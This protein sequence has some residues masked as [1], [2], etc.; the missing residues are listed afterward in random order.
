MQWAQSAASRNICL[1]SILHAKCPVSGGGANKLAFIQR[2]VITLV[3]ESFFTSYIPV[4]FSLAVFDTLCFQYD[5][6]VCISAIACCVVK[7]EA[8]AKFCD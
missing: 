6:S 3:Y 5:T 8:V 7:E 1:C 4:C 2:L